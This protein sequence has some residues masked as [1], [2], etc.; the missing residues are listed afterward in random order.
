[1]E[2]TPQFKRGEEAQTHLKLGRSAV[3]LL[4]HLGET[5]LSIPT[6]PTGQTV[7]P[8]RSRRAELWMTA[9]FYREYECA[10][11]PGAIERALRVLEARAL[12]EA[13]PQPVG[14]RLLSCNDAIVL[15]LANEC[16]QC[17][18]I[19]AGGWAVADALPYAFLRDQGSGPLPVPVD[20]GDEPL[21]RLRQ[22]LDIEDDPSW[23]NILTWLTAAL[24]PDTPCPLLAIDGPAGSGKSTLAKMIKSLIDPSAAAQGY[25]RI[26]DVGDAPDRIPRHLAAM[27]ENQPTIL[28]APRN[29]L[30]PQLQHRASPVTLSARTAFRTLQALRDSFEALHPAVLAALCSI[31]GQAMRDIGQAASCAQ[32]PQA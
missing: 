27:S 18:E 24:R 21:N 20:A 30:T 11:S 19:A 25:L 14:R 10:P 28:V 6:S 3:P 26:L 32:S 29:R 13:I 8:L 1:M 4:S 15:D 12:Y 2:H 5:Y 31:V 17:V 7:L 9:N 16:G 23:S 22:L